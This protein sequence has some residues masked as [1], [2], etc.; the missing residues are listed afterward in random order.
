[1]ASRTALVRSTRN[2]K[3]A[4]QSK[5]PAASAVNTRSRFVLCIDP[6]EYAEVDLDFGKVYQALPT[7]KSARDDGLIR[8]VDNSGED[9]LS[10]ADKFVEIKLPR[11]AQQ[12]VLR[13]R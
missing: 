9:Y 7:E 3:K 10:S 1:M 5:K 6:G 12:A 2:R 11:A 8:V 4:V 13:A